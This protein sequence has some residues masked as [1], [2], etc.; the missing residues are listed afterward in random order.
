[1]PPLGASGGDSLPPRPPP[2]WCHLAQRESP[3]GLDSDVGPGPC[4]R[5]RLSR[6]GTR[7][8]AA[9]S[10]PAKMPALDVTTPRDIVL[11]HVFT[12][13]HSRPTESQ[14]P[15][16]EP[17]DAQ[18][19]RAW[20]PPWMSGSQSVATRPAVL[21]SPGGMFETQSPRHLPNQR[22][23]GRG[24]ARRVVPMQL[25]CE[26][27]HQAEGAPPE[28]ARTRPGHGCSPHAYSTALGTEWA[29][30]HSP[31]S[32]GQFPGHPCP[33]G[34]AWKEL[35]APPKPLGGHTVATVCSRKAAVAPSWPRPPLFR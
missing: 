21:A 35:P 11:M 13:E 22:L 16:A 18:A 1:M 34:P 6:G 27:R 29:Q 23:R 12:P 3:G 7:G 8:A 25:K 9:T 10:A 5:F 19:P 31:E 20:A 24:A 17:D 4:P 30:G 32:R 28:G 14:S 33:G 26:N 2:S 15:K